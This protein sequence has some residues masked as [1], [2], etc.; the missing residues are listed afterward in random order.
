MVFEKRKAKSGKGVGT[1]EQRLLRTNYVHTMTTYW[2]YLLTS[3]KPRTSPI[4]SE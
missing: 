3:P 4:G 2:R 1:S